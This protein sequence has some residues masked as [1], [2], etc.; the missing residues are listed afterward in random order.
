MDAA[1]KKALKQ[2]AKA[3]LE[4]RSVSLEARL[5]A[6]NPESVGSDGWVRNYKLGVEAERWLRKCAPALHAAEANDRFVISRDD[7]TRW[8]PSPQLYC[9]CLTCRS[10]APT[11]LPRRRFYWWSCEC[12][13]LRLRQI[14]W[15]TDY[16]IRHG[17]SLQL[18]KL[19][20]RGSRSESSKPPTPSDDLASRPGMETGRPARGV[21]R[22]R[23]E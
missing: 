8:L 14:L 11:A 16:R 10:V 20:G 17:D 13:N 9:Q 22:R 15:W 19:T 7:P 18:V 21:A 6:S 1:R 3:L 2:T 23:G 5:T 12:G 4:A